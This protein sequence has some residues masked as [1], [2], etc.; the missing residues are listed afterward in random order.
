[1]SPLRTL[2]ATA[3]GIKLTFIKPGHP[4]TNGSCERLHQTLLHEFYIPAL[5][6]KPYASAEDLDYDLQLYLQWYNFRRTHMGRR[7]RGKVPAQVYLSGRTRSS[8]LVLK[9]A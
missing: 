7:L 9:I 5:C 8:E 1:M 3:L 4:W 2:S 6:S